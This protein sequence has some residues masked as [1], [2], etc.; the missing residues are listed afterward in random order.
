M[1]W[2]PQLEVVS[3]WALGKETPSSSQ[4]DSLFCLLLI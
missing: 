4:I 1:L 3:A 2:L